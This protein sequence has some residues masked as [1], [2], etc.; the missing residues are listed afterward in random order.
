RL[1]GA[2]CST[3]KRTALAAE[4]K[5]RGPCASAVARS[6][7]RKRSRGALRIWVFMVIFQPVMPAWKQ[8]MAALRGLSFA[9]GDAEDAVALGQD[10]FHRLA[11]REIGFFHHPLIAFTPGLHPVEH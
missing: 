9:D 7:P 1:T 10:R 8:R 2:A 6:L 4:R 11:R 5:W 3:A